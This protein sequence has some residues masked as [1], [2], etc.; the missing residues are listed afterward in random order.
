MF[1]TF[2]S[3]IFCRDGE[4]SYAGPLS[5]AQTKEMCK[6][7]NGNKSCFSFNW[8]K[9]LYTSDSDSGCFDCISLVKFI[10]QALDAEN[11]ATLEP[12]NLKHHMELFGKCKSHLQSVYSSSESSSVLFGFD[13]STSYFI[14]LLYI[15][16]LK[17]ALL[18][19]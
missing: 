4:K 9:M 3:L 5:K 6:T 2:I 14:V 18:P 8:C 13:S 1:T 11:P 19:H 7:E 17:L 12:E 10:S 15:Y 16:F